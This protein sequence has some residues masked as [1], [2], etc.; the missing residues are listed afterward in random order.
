[1]QE[2]KSIKKIIKDKEAKSLPIC[3]VNKAHQ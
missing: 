1:M 2:R 3:N